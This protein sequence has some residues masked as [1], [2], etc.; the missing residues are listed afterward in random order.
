MKRLGQNALIARIAA[1]NSEPA[2]RD[3]LC[4]IVSDQPPVPGVAEEIPELDQ[5]VLHGMSAAARRSSM[6][7]VAVELLGCD[8]GQRH[9]LRGQPAQEDSRGGLVGI[10]ALWDIRPEVI[11]IALEQIVDHSGHPISI[12]AG[13]PLRGL[14][15][16]LDFDPGR[17]LRSWS[18][19][20]ARSARGRQSARS[21]VDQLSAANG[22][23]AAVMDDRRLG[24]QALN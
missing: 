16:R 22:T 12:E 4:W 24:E 13:G 7:E 2:A 3:I 21:D 17:E 20:R 11:G 19:R 6:A 15:C 10:S 1:G 9:V 18:G 23:L 5:I 8:P 14:C